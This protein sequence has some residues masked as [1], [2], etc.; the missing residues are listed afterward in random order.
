[1]P[2]LVREAKGIISGVASLF[3]SASSESSSTTGA[4]TGSCESPL[5]NRR[6]TLEPAGHPG[7]SDQCSVCTSDTIRQT[8][9]LPERL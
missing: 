3:A 1:M 6:W 4:A 5:F 2:S 7:F 8:A 9:L